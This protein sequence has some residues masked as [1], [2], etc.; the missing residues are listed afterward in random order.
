MRGLGS[1][2]VILHYLSCRLGT[3]EP[4]LDYIEVFAG[5]KGW[6]NGMASYHLKGLSIDV[7]DA[8]EFDIMTK[9]GFC[10]IL[11]AIRRIKR[12]GVIHFGPPCSSWAPLIYI[13]IYIYMLFF[14]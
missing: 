9:L 13:Y 2:S 11:S 14:T 5:D 3:P 6:S 7:R 12:G 10:F 1:L 8:K 4:E